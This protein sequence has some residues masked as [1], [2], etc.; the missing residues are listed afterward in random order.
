MIDIERKAHVLHLLRMFEKELA[1][2]KDSA[3]GAIALIDPRLGGGDGRFAKICAYYKA[4]D[5]LVLSM[6]DPELTSKKF[7]YV[8]KG[9]LNRPIEDVGNEI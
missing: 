5:T 4:I 3:V 6:V 7:D 2:S 8:D 1:N 9:I